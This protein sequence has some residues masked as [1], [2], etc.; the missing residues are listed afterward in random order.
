LVDGGLAQLLPHALERRLQ[1]AE[2]VA[3][4][5]LERPG[6]VTLRDAVG[7]LDERGDRLVHAAPGPPGQ[8][9]SEDQCDRAE[10][11]GEDQ[12]LAQLVPLHRIE[13]VARGRGLG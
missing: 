7:A 8:R 5:D 9:E 10:T 11:A 13:L 1:L 6:V 12:R 3:S 4:P 2:L